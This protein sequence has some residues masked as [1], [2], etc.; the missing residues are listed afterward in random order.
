MI[1]KVFFDTN[2]IL[3]A[4]TRRDYSFKPSLELIRFIIDKKI[5]GYICIKQ[6]TD[7]YYILRKYVDNISTQKNVIKDIIDIFKILPLLK[8]DIT[9]SLYNGIADFEDAVLE[10]VARTNTMNYLVTN[11]ISHFRDSKMVVVTP[12]QLL[13]LIELTIETN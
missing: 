3:D 10:E 1:T 12:T 6:I 2:V 13:E 8:S 9:A 7:I 5:D 11:D 4:F